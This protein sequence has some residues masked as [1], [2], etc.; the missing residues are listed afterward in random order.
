MKNGLRR[1]EEERSH[2]SIEE[3]D[4]DCV[5]DESEEQ[6]VEAPAPR[7]LGVVLAFFTTGLECPARAHI[8]LN[9][10][11]LEVKV[12]NRDSGSQ[13]VELGKKDLRIHVKEMVIAEPPR[14][15]R[16][17]FDEVAVM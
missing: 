10:D 2:H 6:E 13:E 7:G 1:R 14:N 16:E 11:K 12:P 15:P 8:C 4:S 3:S 9:T 5:C 17:V